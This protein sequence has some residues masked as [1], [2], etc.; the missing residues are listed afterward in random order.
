MGRSGG[1]DAEAAARR[2][3]GVIAPFGI[4]TPSGDGTAPDFRRLRMK[5]YGRTVALG[6]Y[7]ASA[8]A[9][10]YELDLD[11]RRHLKKQRRQSERTF[12]SSLIRLRKQRGLRRTD[13]R[14]P[15]PPSQ[16]APRAQ[17]NRK[18]PCED[19]G[20]S[21]RSTWGPR[22]RDRQLLRSTSRG[23]LRWPS[24]GGRR[25]RPH[26]SVWPCDPQPATPIAGRE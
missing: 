19:V 10:L 20:N 17:R 11:Y 6:D 9:I 26:D 12:G 4:F 7:E 21:G 24:I 13:C 16:S 8:D 22:E 15:F 14:R 3:D 18:T 2:R 23:A 25:S 5:D 1:K